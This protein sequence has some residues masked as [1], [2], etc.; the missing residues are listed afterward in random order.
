MSSFFVLNPI[1]FKFSAEFLSFIQLF[2]DDVTT[3]LSYRCWI[4]SW[5][6][7]HISANAEY[8]STVSVFIYQ[9]FSG[10]LLGLRADI[11]KVTAHER[12]V[13]MRAHSS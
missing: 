2:G 8:R 1:Y 5:A 4:F 10:L 9:F 11:S 6:M 7:S 3:V 13:P 12:I